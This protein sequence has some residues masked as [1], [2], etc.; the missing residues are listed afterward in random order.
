MPLRAFRVFQQPVESAA[1]Q[2]V[3]SVTD[4]LNQISIGEQFSDLRD[5]QV[6]GSRVRCDLVD[7]DFLFG[8][9]RGKI[10]EEIGE[11][12]LKFIQKRSSVQFR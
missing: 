6:G 3:A 8:S 9:S 5:N 4:Q 7:N 10:D 12:D 1:G 11:T 2:N